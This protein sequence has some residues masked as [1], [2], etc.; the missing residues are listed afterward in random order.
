MVKRRENQEQPHLRGSS[1][2]KERNIWEDPALLHLQEKAGVK[3]ESTPSVSPSRTKQR[4]R[5]PG[6][7]W[8]ADTPRKRLFRGS[9]RVRPRHPRARNHGVQPRLLHSRKQGKPRLFSSPQCHRTFVLSGFDPE[10]PAIPSPRPA[11]A[12]PS[13]PGPRP[14]AP[15]V[16]GQHRLTPPAP[17]GCAAGRTATRGPRAGESGLVGTLLK[18]LSP[19]ADLQNNKHPHPLPLPHGPRPRVTRVR[20]RALLSVAGSPGPSMAPRLA[21][22]SRSP[23]G[24]LGAGARPAARR[25]GHA[26]AAAADT[27]RGRPPHARRRPGRE[28]G[29]AARHTFPLAVPPLTP[30]R[31][32]SPPVGCWWF[33]RVCSLSPAMARAAP[34]CGLRARTHAASAP[35][36][37]PAP[38]ARRRRRRPPLGA[39]AGLLSRR[40]ERLVRAAAARLHPR[41][42]QRDAAAPIRRAA[43]CYSPRRRRRASAPPPPAGS[44]RG[45]S[46]T[47]RPPGGNPS[48]RPWAN[49]GKESGRAAFERRLPPP[50]AR[51]CKAGGR[52]GSRREGRRVEPHNQNGLQRGRGN[53]ELTPFTRYPG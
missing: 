18:A 37:R 51:G 12:G 16:S 20:G 25:A 26:V 36:P 9:L 31:K 6:V 13:C 1:G 38:S 29:G 4:E 34:P 7:G 47:S 8:G 52:L 15:A 42:G 28:G 22:G 30:I 33:C 24:R 45:A 53:K 40:S 11:Q 39:G 43:R 10:T 23:R 5:A 49:P 50:L 2:S 32:G 35:R 41:G 48:P 3:E 46:A 14:R 21:L 27:A 19:P 44:G 17:P